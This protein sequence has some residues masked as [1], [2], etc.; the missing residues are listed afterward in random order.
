MSYEYMTFQMALKLTSDRKY[1]LTVTY[2]QITVANST[3]ISLAKYLDTCDNMTCYIHR[4]STYH[5][6]FLLQWKP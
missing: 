3:K 6:F 2:N 5:F 1:T 4:P